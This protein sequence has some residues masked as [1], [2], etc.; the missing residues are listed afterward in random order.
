M[1]LTFIKKVRKVGG[2]LVVTIPSEIIDISNLAEG[3]Y[4]Q[5]QIEVINNKAEKKIKIKEVYKIP[6]ELKESIKQALP[7]IYKVENK[8]NKET[9]KINMINQYKKDKRT[10][11]TFIEPTDLKEFWTTAS[12][13]KETIETNNLYEFDSD[14]NIYIDIGTALADLGFITKKRTGSGIKRLIHIDKLNLPNDIYEEDK[15]HF[16]LVDAPKKL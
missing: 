7:I 4:I 8:I 5:A 11:P 14:R 6:E 15:P 1:K 12:H 13:I 9:S 3:N 16:K 2:A 10:P